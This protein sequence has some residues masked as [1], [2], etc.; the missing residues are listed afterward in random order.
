[1]S[2]LAAAAL[3][4]LLVLTTVPASAQEAPTEVAE[5]PVACTNDGGLEVVTAAGL[6]SKITTPAFDGPGEETKEYLVDLGASSLDATAPVDIEM[7]W[8]LAVNDYDLGADSAASS[9]ISENYQPFDPNLESVRLDVVK[10]CEIITVRAI[11]FLAPV[12]LDELSLA[13]KV[14]PVV[15]PAPAA[16]PTPAP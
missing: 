7:A 15:T 10:H 5:T 11:N 6:Q 4:L 3:F 13:F 9:G 8:D 1:M 16:E 14:G 2:R 12:D